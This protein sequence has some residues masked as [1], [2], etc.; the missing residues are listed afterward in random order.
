MVKYNISFLS[1]LVQYTDTNVKWTWCQQFEYIYVNSIN[2][3]L[4]VYKFQTIN[5][6]LDSLLKL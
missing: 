4:Y 2:K 6:L 1:S 3:S 5:V